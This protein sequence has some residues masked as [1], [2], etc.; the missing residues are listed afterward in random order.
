M[1]GIAFLSGLISGLLTSAIVLPVA[2]QVTSDGTT[3]TNVNSIGNNFNILNGIQKGNNLF[4]SFG[5]FSIPTGG[6]ATFNNSTDVVNIINRVTGGN[7]S[8]IDGLIKANGSANLFLINPAGIVFG[9]NASLDIGGSFLGTTAQSLLFEDGFNYSAIDPDQAPLLTVSVPLGLQMGKNPGAITNQGALLE[10]PS[11][12]TL[13][14]VGGDISQIGGELRLD[15]GGGR[16]ELAAMEENSEIKL[17]PVSGG[18]EL[19]A[20]NTESFK[21]IQ[22]TQGALVN[23]SGTGS[24]SINIAAKSFLLSDNS[25]FQADNR[26]DSSGGSVTINANSSILVQEG[27]RIRTETVGSGNAPDILLYAPKISLYNDAKLISVAVEGTGNGGAI[28][29]EGQEVI[30]ASDPEF[31]AS[32]R[33]G[34]ISVAQD[35]GRGSNINIEADSIYFFPGSITNLTTG[36]GKSGS[37]TLKAKTITILSG[38]GNTGA[39]GAGDADDLNF[40]ADTFYM[41]NSGFSASSSGSGKAGNINVTARSIIMRDAGL[42]GSTSGSGNAGN[43][44]LKADYIELDDASHIPSRTTG[45]GNGGNINVSS[46]TLRLLNGSQLNVTTKAS[47][48][49]GRI[50]VSG[51]TVELNGEPTTGQLA[52]RNTGLISSVLPDIQNPNAL[53]GN[54][55]N[56]DLNASSLM[57]RDG[58]VIAA[59]TS[60]GAGNGGD[61]NLDVDRLDILNGGQVMNLT[62][63]AGN[64]G[65]VTVNAGDEILIN[66]SDALHQER[67]LAYVAGQDFADVEYNIGALSGIFAN[68]TQTASGDGGNLQITGGNLRIEDGA[69]ISVSSLGTGSAGS[70]SA[71]LDTLTLDQQASLEAESAAGSNGNLF[72]NV[73]KAVILRQGSRITTNATGKANGGNINIDSP[74]I[75]SFENSDIIANAVAGNGGNI[76]VATQGIFGLEFRDSLTQESDITASSEFGV[77]GTVKINNIGIDPGSGLVELSAELADSSQQIASG[78]SRNTGSTFVATGRGGIPNNPNQSLN[79][80]PTWSDIRDLSAYSKP[81]NNLAEVRSISNKP[82]IVEATHFIRNADGEIELVALQNTPLRTPAPDCSSLNT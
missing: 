74:V 62:R 23:V 7:I 13:G 56:I 57:I 63:N 73:D 36:Q 17:N 35:R 4:H 43:I 51:N 20:S 49:G 59:S 10:V 41:S 53:T 76:N 77:N 50:T 22:F 45:L 38:G 1:K 80:N 65:T 40:I 19:D 64:A 12:N 26:G 60:A 81:N 3:N 8:N 9:E 27:G 68:T 54:A 48:N 28:T 25:R 11:G 39:R 46:Q 58:A 34:I 5:E 18:W 70:F 71:A 69:K 29:L 78:C 37:T 2:A 82:A 14:L 52:N 55:G 33:N 47:G 32:K 24:A 21:D 66:G 44:N 16:I 15:G 79:L 67:Q 61:I 42:S 6:S 30:F 31:I 72:L 75:A